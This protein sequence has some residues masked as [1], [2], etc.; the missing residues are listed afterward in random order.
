V[1][2][3]RVSQYIEQLITMSQEENFWIVPGPPPDHLVG[4]AEMNSMTFIEQVASY[5]GQGLFI[6]LQDHMV[7]E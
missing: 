4:S 3:F 7:V 6:T 5:S 2:V 1:L